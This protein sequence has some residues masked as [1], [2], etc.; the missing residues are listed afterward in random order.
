[1]FPTLNL[2]KMS[3]VVIPHNAGLRPIT[4]LAYQR[5]IVDPQVLTLYKRLGLSRRGVKLSSF[6]KDNSDSLPSP[7]VKPLTVY[8]THGG[9]DLKFDDVHSCDPQWCDRLKDRLGE[10]LGTTN[11]LDLQVVDGRKTVTLS[12]DS[13]SFGSLAKAKKYQVKVVECPGRTRVSSSS[14]SAA[15]KHVGI[16][17][18]A[19]QREQL[20]KGHEGEL[21]R[22]RE[23][24]CNDLR[25]GLR[26][27]IIDAL[28]KNATATTDNKMTVDD[29]VGVSMM[30]SLKNRKDQLNALGKAL[31]CSDIGALQT[32]LL[33]SVCASVAEQNIGAALSDATSTSERDNAIE[34]LVGYGF[35]Q[36]SAI[37]T[38]RKASAQDKPIGNWF[39]NLFTGF[40][41]YKQ[42]VCRRRYVHCLT[43]VRVLKCQQFPDKKKCK[44]AK[45]CHRVKRHDSE[46]DSDSSSDSDR[47]LSP[48]ATTTPSVTNMTFVR[49]N[50]YTYNAPTNDSSTNHNT[51]KSESSTTHYGVG[52]VEHRPRTDGGRSK[53]VY[54]AGRNKDMYGAGYK[55]KRSTT[56]PDTMTPN[57]MVNMYGSTNPMSPQTMS[58]ATLLDMRA[59]R[60]VPT[61][62]GAD[63]DT[64]RG[65][66]GTNTNRGTYNDYGTNRGAYND[67]GTNMTPE[68]VTPGQL[69][70]TAATNSFAT[71]DSVHPGE[72]MFRVDVTRAPQFDKEDKRRAYDENSMRYT[73]DE[74]SM[75]YTDDGENSMRYT[76]DEEEDK[77]G[78]AE[79]D[80]TALL[81]L[82]SEDSQ[83]RPSG[84][85]I[86]RSKGDEKKKK[87]VVIASKFHG[88]ESS[89]DE[90]D[91]YSA[92]RVTMSDDTSAAASATKLVPASAD[93][94]GN[95]VMMVRVQKECGRMMAPSGVFVSDASGT[96][97]NLKQ[98]GDDYE[99]VVGKH[100]FS[101]NVRYTPPADSTHFVVTRSGQIVDTTNAR[102]N[103]L[104]ADDVLDG[105]VYLLVVNP[106]RVHSCVQ[107]RSTANDSAHTVALSPN[108]SKGIK[109]PAGQYHF[110]PEIGEEK[111]TTLHTGNSYAGVMPAADNEQFEEMLENRNSDVKRHIC[112]SFL[113]RP[114][115]DSFV[116]AANTPNGV[117]FA[118]TDAKNAKCGSPVDM[119]NHF[120]VIDS[121]QN[122]EVPSSTDHRYHLSSTSGNQL[123]MLAADKTHATTTSGQRLAVHGLFAHPKNNKIAVAVFDGTPADVTTDGL[124][125]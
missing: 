85:N 44:K 7:A 41:C 107:I 40:H 32:T 31:F 103:A 54:G 74:N 5:Q 88:A 56:T 26:G 27:D 121:R 39:T 12:N 119:S 65:A 9:R 60:S 86:G 76:D 84:Q 11:A 50:T 38:L 8:V 55:D 113:S 36:S 120:C 3:A 29:V 69:M 93:K 105:K 67:Y 21:G 46:S 58:P 70:S 117:L 33:S 2:F 17:R 95:R 24:L 116:R 75:R 78:I 109:L 79:T 73:D 104:T 114:E 16:Y 72:L 42:P 49:N 19:E 97:T 71:P 110:R 98:A 83:R 30:N 77:D 90:E 80:L 18:T 51:S 10:A 43:P 124:G 112:Q 13:K 63:N 125:F 6:L 68:I 81:S 92:A 28:K 106:T 96:R 59:N 99:R 108:E 123:Y 57:T 111:L 35:Q 52:S 37:K 66:Y 1:M 23:A 94:S 15:P 122:L 87:K 20:A 91:H 101:K 115:V 61:N 89:D 34:K 45:K 25:R 48:R 118:P 64:N 82:M 62:R 47:E 100:L 53:D 102:K 4:R 14:L 22:Q